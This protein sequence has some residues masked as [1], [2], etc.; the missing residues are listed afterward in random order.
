MG[1]PKADSLDYTFEYQP[2]GA[3][4]SDGRRVERRL[5]KNW[6]EKNL[7]L[8]ILYVISEVLCSQLDHVQSWIG[9][10]PTLVCHTYQLRGPKAPVGRVK[11]DT[12][13]S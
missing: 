4:E 11:L 12:S 1:D 10:F 3:T 5:L 2:G 8:R 13:G 9:S 6:G 7:Q